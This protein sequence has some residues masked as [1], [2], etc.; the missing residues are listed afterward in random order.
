MNTDTGEIRRM[1]G[2]LTELEEKFGGKGKWVELSEE[3]VAE[4]IGKLIADPTVKK[5]VIRKN[6]QNQIQAVIPQR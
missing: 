4:Q 3:K 6:R 2:S 5:I 1:E